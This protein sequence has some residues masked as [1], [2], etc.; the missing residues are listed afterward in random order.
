MGLGLVRNFRIRIMEPS[1]ADF[2]DRLPMEDVVLTPTSR[3][4]LPYLQAH[5]Q[6]LEDLRRLLP[7]ALNGIE[8][9]WALH[10]DRLILER[11]QLPGSA[12]P[13]EE[14]LLWRAL[15]PGLAQPLHAWWVNGGWRFRIWDAETG[16]QYDQREVIFF[17]R[18][19]LRTTDTTEADANDLLNYPFLLRLALAPVALV[20]LPFVLVSELRGNWRSASPHERRHM[21]LGG[22]LVW[23]G[24]P[25]ALLYP[26]LLETR[27]AARLQRHMQARREAVEQQQAIARLMERQD[28]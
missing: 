13:L 27:L 22:A 5:P 25:L 14:M 23:V 21:L 26:R 24:M 20:A 18:G 6:R 7:N 15:F 8:A 3:L 28:T 9:H 11:L 1:Y 16:A 2:V 17:T 10:D 19:R 12:D 4:L